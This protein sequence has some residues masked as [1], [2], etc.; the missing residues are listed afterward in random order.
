MINL[1]PAQNISNLNG[2]NIKLSCD[3]IM[4]TLLLQLILTNWLLI[5]QASVKVW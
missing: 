3:K 2:L 4:K 1:V 5:S